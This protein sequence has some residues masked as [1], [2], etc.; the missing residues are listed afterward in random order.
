MVFTKRVDVPILKPNVLVFYR[1]L[2][3]KSRP[4]SFPAMRHEVL[5]P[6]A[7]L[8][9]NILEMIKKPNRILK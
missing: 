2:R 8:R 7:H 6:L 9:S 5:I 3:A 4:V 1:C